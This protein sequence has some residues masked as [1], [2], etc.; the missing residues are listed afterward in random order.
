MEMAEA[1]LPFPVAIVV[2][3]SIGDRIQAVAVIR[4]LDLADQVRSTADRILHRS[5]EAVM[6]EGLAVL[7]DTVGS[8]STSYIALAASV[9]VG[10]NCEPNHVRSMGPPARDSG[11]F[12]AQIHNGSML[13]SRAGGQ[14]CIH[15]PGAHATEQGRASPRSGKSPSRA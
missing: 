4:D 12:A 14:C 15:G 10:L 1:G 3:H 11:T 2:G 7:V 5:I 13:R 6:D 8:V 9:A